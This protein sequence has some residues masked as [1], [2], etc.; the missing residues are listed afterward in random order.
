M[1]FLYLTLTPALSR[2]GRG[3][4]RGNGHIEFSLSPGG[5]GEG[6]GGGRDGRPRVSLSVRHEMAPL[7][8]TAFHLCKG[9]KRVKTNTERE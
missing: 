7:Q 5:R 9:P 6:E 3:G 2:Q 4:R 1:C 8:E